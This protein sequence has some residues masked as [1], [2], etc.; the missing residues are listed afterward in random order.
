M[1]TYQGRESNHIHVIA[2]GL[3]VQGEHLILCR[4]KDAKWMFLPGGH[5][6][7]GESAKVALLRELNE[8]MGI[9]NGE[10]VDF[11]GVCENVF[12]LEED[13]LQHEINIVFKVS[14]PQ[15]T[16][17]SNKEDHIEF[18]KIETKDLAN[19]KFLPESL[20]SSLVSWLQNGEKF[21]KEI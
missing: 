14:I 1:K 19:Q 13:V 6:E 3:L 20:K 15:N 2:R 17:L 9:M 16:E 18:V 11:L 10:V 5:V 4:V 8:E 7:D 12:N 21:F